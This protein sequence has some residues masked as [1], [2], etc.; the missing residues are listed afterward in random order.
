LRQ[1]VSKQVIRKSQ[2]SL[3]PLIEEALSFIK[4][5][6]DENGITTRLE[7][8]EELPPLFVDPVQIEQVMLNLMRNSI[9]AMAGADLEEKI[10]AVVA[11]TIDGS[12]IQVTVEDT[13]PGLNED[14]IEHIFDAFFT[15]KKNGM[16]MGLAISRSIIET[17]GGRLW[18]ES[19][20]DKGARFHFNLPIT[21]GA[22]SDE[23]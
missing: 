6:A 13:G 23:Q 9:E 2:L 7:L 3:Q 18:A 8:A 19:G 5:E 21:E 22:G 16:G 1:F 15:T 10:I 4:A 20:H 12:S 17:H 14:Q 11:V